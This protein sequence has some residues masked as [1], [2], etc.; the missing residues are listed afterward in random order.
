[1]S[2]FPP[3]RRGADKL[4]NVCI[5]STNELEQNEREYGRQNEKETEGGLERDC[6]HCALPNLVN[7]LKALA[8]KQ[9]LFCEM[10]GIFNPP[11]DS[12]SLQAANG[13]KST[14]NKGWPEGA[15]I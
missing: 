13:I 4:L 9:M 15:S 6:C 11:P 12:I 5:V 14:S 7:G 1:M 2:R 3:Q 8:G 10:E